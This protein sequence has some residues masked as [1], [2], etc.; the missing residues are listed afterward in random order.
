L[1]I[2]LILRGQTIGVIGI[3]RS[4]DE[5]SVAANETAGWSEDELITIQT[6]SEQ[7]ALALDSARLARDTERAAWRDRLV[8][9][10]TAQVWASTEVEEVMQTAVAQLGNKLGAT[11]VII[12]LTTQPK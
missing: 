8:S 11:E 2:P 10:S 6:V 7:V 5:G 1:A 12:R 9:E 4:V 3:E